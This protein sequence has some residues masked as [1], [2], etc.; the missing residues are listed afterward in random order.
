MARPADPRPERP[1]TYRAALRTRVFRLMLTAHGIGTVGQL[2]LTLAVGL[3]VLDRT[4]SGGWVS[5]TVALGFVPYVLASGYAGMLADR[6][7]RSAVLTL[8]L[9]V[10]AACAAALAMGFLLSWPVPVLVSIAAMAAFAATPAYPALAAATV[11]SVPDQ[12]LPAA[13]ALLTGVVNLTWMAGPGVLGLA[14]M[15]GGGPGVG[16]VLAAALFLVASL[17]SGRVRLPR[18]DRPDRTGGTW[19]E[20]R[21]GLRAVARVGTVRRPMAVA[22]LDNFLYG[23]LVVAIVL[24]AD[25]STAGRWMLGPVNAA[26]SI[27]GMLAMLTAN[28]FAGHLRPRSLLLLALCTFAG[29]VGLLAVCPRTGP[30]MVVAGL[31]GATPLRAV[32]TAVTLVQRATAGELT[33]RVFGIYD[34]IT[35]GAIALGSL[36]AGPLADGLGAAPAMALV[37]SACLLTAVVLAGPV[38]EPVRR[39]R[40]AAPRPPR[41]RRGLGPA[42]TH[43]VSRPVPVRPIEHRSDPGG[44]MGRRSTSEAR[45]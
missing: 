17:V 3:E 36:V 13:N 43:D 22:A 34:Q 29:S 42:R 32:V 37:A 44:H 11:H 38:G 15:V 40:H 25:E 20:L 41:R 19:P 39:G 10:R 8:S 31:A 35:V 21:A 7:S 1:P 23:Y 26:L 45:S 28:L 24:L 16:T 18:P 9:G 33:A 30:A 12:A 2:M 27:G 5:V 14:L 4:G 6:R